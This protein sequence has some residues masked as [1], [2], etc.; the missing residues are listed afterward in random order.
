MER[1][2]LRK[3]LVV[4]GLIGI[5]ASAAVAYADAPAAKWYDTLSIGGYVQGSYVGNLVAP[6][7]P[8]TT[9]AGRQYDQNPNSFG[10]NGVL[11][12]I[13][14]PVGDDHYGFVTKLLAGSDANVL[15]NGNSS[16][17]NTLFVEEAYVTYAIPSLTKLQI[18]GGKFLTPEGYEGA[19]TVYNPNFSEG[20]LFTYA[21]PVT[22]TGIKGNYTFSDKVNA[23]LGV[24]NG[25]DST[26]DINQ[27][28][29]ILWQIATAPTKQITWSVQGLYGPELTG[30]NNSVRSSFDTVL[31][32]TPM[33]KLTLALQGNWGQQTND[34]NTSAG[35][36]TTHWSGIGLWASYAL[37]DMFT[38]S[39]RFEVMADQ[40]D[41]ARFYAGTAPAPVPFATGTNQ[42]VKEFTLTHK[43]MLTKAMG[44][45]LEYRHDWSNEP[46]FNGN[47]TAVRNQNTI[48][49]DFFVTF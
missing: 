27:G 21:E 30:T 3:G 19:N 1:S 41:A 12:N 7:N 40:N 38:E 28:K 32:Y 17:T 47:T 14:K 31:G 26:D 42:T 45:R 35:E 37:S 22:H 13:S 6:H 18:S 46:Y 49:A 20:L 44:T 34:P 29:T 16:T 10:L 39:V 24:V 43:T 36:G 23:T 2:R 48:S 25:W 4:N 33:D 15:A 9:N 5:M 8:G 11:L